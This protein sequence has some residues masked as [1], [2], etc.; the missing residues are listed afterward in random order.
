MRY[1]LYAVAFLSGAGT[2]FMGAWI[3][4]IRHYERRNR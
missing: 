4:L 3:V 1:L 2:V